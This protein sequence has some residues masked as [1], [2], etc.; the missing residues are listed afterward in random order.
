MLLI[1]GYM[2][3]LRHYAHRLNP[4]FHLD[5]QRYYD[6]LHPTYRLYSLTR[7]LFESREEYRQRLYR[8]AA[9][10]MMVGARL[11]LRLMDQQGVN[12]RSVAPVRAPNRSF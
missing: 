2:D 6:V 10:Y 3:T 8:D 11:R 1:F 5:G 9:Y 12:R 4:V 7:S